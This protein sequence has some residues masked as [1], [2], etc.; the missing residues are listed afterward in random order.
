[1][2]MNELKVSRNK[3]RH[4]KG[5]G[6]AAGQGKTAGKGTKGQKART[7]H[8]KREGFEGGQT[9]IMMRLPKLR[10]F[11]SHRTPPEVIFSDELNAL[12]G[13]VSNTHVFEAGLV[14]GPFVSVR[15]L[16]RGE[17]TSKVD[18]HLQG[19]S[20]SAKSSV[21]KAGGTFK[22]V[23]RPKRLSTKVEN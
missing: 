23:D 21:I 5:I 16:G 9:P 20:S 19:M 3:P 8:G 22:K 12:K 7:G 1:M 2:K 15:V 11:K 14:S 4:R 17:V 18:V 10:G 13:T 6:I